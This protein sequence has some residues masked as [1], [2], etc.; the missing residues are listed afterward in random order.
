M[1]VHRSSN[2]SKARINQNV[3][4]T[5]VIIQNIKNLA[6]YAKI[7]VNLLGQIASKTSLTCHWFEH[8]NQRQSLVTNTQLLNVFGS[9]N[10]DDILLT[11]RGP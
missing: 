3:R 2:S 4:I 9:A 1:I 10:F 7:T 11:I 6:Y 8:S 5:S